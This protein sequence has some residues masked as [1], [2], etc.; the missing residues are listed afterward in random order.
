[1]LIGN[2]STNSS[3]FDIGLLIM[4]RDIICDPQHILV[5]VVNWSLFKLSDFRT[6]G[7]NAN[8]N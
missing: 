8:M 7:L 6:L 1:M 3:N 5:S 2:L 4:W